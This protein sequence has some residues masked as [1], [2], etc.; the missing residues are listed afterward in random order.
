MAADTL[1]GGADDA[2][3]FPPRL[4]RPRDTIEDVRPLPWDDDLARARDAY[5]A[6]ID[7]WTAL[8]ES[9]R[10]APEDLLFERRLTEPERQA[11]DSTLL[12]AAGDRSAERVD[13]VRSSLLPR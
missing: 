10:D 2:A 9:T 7:A 5:L 6:R 1:S 3:R 12:E 4:Q 8:V 13:A 11:A